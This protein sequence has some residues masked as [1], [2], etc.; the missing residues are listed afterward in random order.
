MRSRPRVPVYLLHLCMCCVST[1]LPLS[2]HQPSAWN[3]PCQPHPGF[4]RNLLTSSAQLHRR[5]VLSIAPS[6][7]IYSWE[8]KC[9]IKMGHVQGEVRSSRGTQAPLLCLAQLHFPD[10]FGGGVAA[11]KPSLRKSSFSSGSSLWSTLSTQACQEL[12]SPLPALCW[13]QCHHHTL[14]PA[15]PFS[16]DF[17]TWWGLESRGC[18][19]MLFSSQV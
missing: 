13:G 3:P 9:C 2:N 4:L 7:N 5:T 19:V 6:T 16:G 17:C 11:A 14:L 10:R 8:G 1:C 18:E 12:A 15:G